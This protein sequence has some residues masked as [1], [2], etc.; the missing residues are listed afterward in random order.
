MDSTT[1][2]PSRRSAGIV[3]V[4]AFFAGLVLVRTTLPLIDGDV[5][6]HLRAGETVL[7]ERAVPRIDTWTIA[8]YGMKWT[9]QDWLSNTLMAAIHG[10]SDT[11]GPTLLSLAFGLVV[12]IGFALLW[13][14]V[15][16]R[17]PGSS[18]AARAL[19]LTAG[20]LVAA[21]V[22]GVRVQTVDLALLAAATWLLW[23]YLVDRRVRSLIGLPVLAAAWA[24][25][26]AG[27]PLL[28]ALGGAVIVGEA[29]DRM[30]SRVVDQRPPLEWHEI[31]SLAAALLVSV[32][33]LLFNPNGADLLAYPLETAGIA[34]H[35]DVLVEWSPPDLTTFP[36][37]AFLAFA[38]IVVLPTLILGRRHLRSA[39]ML[40]LLGL[41][42]LAAG[43]VRFVLAAGPIC[44][45]IAAVAL[46]P[47]VGTHPA[48]AGLARRA[49]ALQR[50]PDDGRRAAI[51]VALAVLI[52]AVGVGVAAA[53]VSP[54]QQQAAVA[55]AMPVRATEWL[56][57]SFGAQRIFNVYAWGGWIGRELPERLV[58]IDGRSD[59][60]GDA[61]IREYAEAISLQTD[62]RQLL[63]RAEV[64]AVVFWPESELADWLDEQPEWRRVH[65]DD[66]AAIWIREP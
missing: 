47:A 9:S 55:Q 12:V 13:N 31:G 56:S 4:A 14:A 65:E 19:L 2:H 22:L 32:A 25:L 52:V 54:A 41:T 8:G 37:Q 44:A 35:R 27:W 33:A 63:D 18:W 61:I 48:V 5:W 11:W 38:V 10:V 64:D 58:Y 60:Y 17:N 23:S 16:R 29:I 34:A 40:W 26:H 3:V 66:L 7:A 62:P 6:W 43:A 42:V 28:F 45:A 50:P 20:L 15:G 49:A 1:F 36:G 57:S 24:N 21:P 59:I 51:N 30:A 46:A 39:D 53:R